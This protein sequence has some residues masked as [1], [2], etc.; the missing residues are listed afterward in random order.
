MRR[1]VLN[2][3]ISATGDQLTLSLLWLVGCLP[4]VTAPAA[5]AALF[6]VVRQRRR[7]EDPALGRAFLAA[8]RHYLRSSL[9]VG[10]GWAAVGLVLAGDLVIVARLGLPAGDAL[11]VALLVL[12]LLYAMGSAALF[13]VLVSYQARPFQLLRTAVVVALLFPVRT[14]LALASLAAAVVACWAVPLAI[15]LAPGLAATAILRAYGGA[16]DRLRERA[17]QSPPV[18]VLH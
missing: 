14:G 7:G 18:A 2:R 9:L 12:L 1:P 16:F 15:V 13:P 5:T 10:Y 3:F 17:G 6:E 4:L 8:G 11:Q